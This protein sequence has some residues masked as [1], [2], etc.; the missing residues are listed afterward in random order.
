[1]QDANGTQIARGPIGGDNIGNNYSW[2]TYFHGGPR[3]HR[4]VD[5][6][7]RKAAGQR[8]TQTHLSDDFRTEVTNEWVVAVS[9]PVAVEDRFLGVVGVFLYI[10]PPAP[11]DTPPGEG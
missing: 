5:D 11:A 6:D 9:A 1:M 2:R 8:L 7:R 3:D 4:D 10:M